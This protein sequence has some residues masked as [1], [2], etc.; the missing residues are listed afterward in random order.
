[1][2]KGD[3]LN[4]DFA[5]VLIDQLV[6]LGIELFCIAP[7]RR[8]TPL[9]VAA[10]SHPKAKTFVHFDERGVAFHALGYGKATG[11]PAAVITTSGSALGNVMP[12]VMEAHASNIPLL[13]LTADRPHELREAMANQTCDQLKIFGGYVRHFFEMPTPDPTLPDSFLATTLSQAYR[14]C[15][16]GPVHLNCPFKEPFDGK[17]QLT[18]QKKP[19]ETTFG[20]LTLSNEVASQWATSLSEI[21][22]GVIV[23]G[24]HNRSEHRGIETLAKKLGWPV[25]PDIN[26]SYRSIP[27]RNEIP[28]YPYLV[29]PSEEKADLIL[30]FGDSVVSK[31]LLQW[32]PK[33]KRVIHVSSHVKRC[34]PSH[35]VTD[36]VVCD[37]NLFAQKVAKQISSKLG[38]YY[39]YWKEKSDQVHE[40]LSSIFEN[41]DELSEMGVVWK[42]GKTLT[43]DQALFIGNSMP[44]RDA[45]C[46]LF[47]K[48]PIG[49]LFSN[50]GLSGI[51]GNVATSAG[52]AQTLPTF[53]LIGDQTLLYDLNSLAQ[54]PKTPHPVQI[55][56]INN[57]GGQIFSYFTPPNKKK[58]WET[59]FNAVHSMDFRNAAELFELSYQNVKTP[60]E[61]NFVKPGIIEVNTSCEATISMH[62]RIIKEIENALCT[63]SSMVF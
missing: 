36:R 45:D 56:V 48:A 52:I 8:S 15:S 63:S 38:N 46:L 6:Q 24:T 20:E 16:S 55:I 13:L 22:K 62:K 19:V 30:Q 51:D 59:H 35:C 42:L 14:Y 41:E 17:A 21:E 57:Q 11:K 32:I 12:A 50:R 58:M 29:G 49:P 43:S 39:S 60:Q 10:A 4:S 44:I 61:L 26:S 53:A 7:G 40:I 54:L 37:P 33:H 27:G 47:P 3:S 25:F 5:E 9:V 31:R 1:M 28:Y 2:G 34:D 23:V 18:T